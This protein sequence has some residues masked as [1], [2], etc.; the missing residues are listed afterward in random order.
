MALRT[1]DMLAGVMQ[2]STRSSRRSAGFGP[3]LFCLV[4]PWS[5][6]S[7]GAQ[8]PSPPVEKTAPAPPE[9]GQPAPSF[10]LND[11]DGK[12]VAIGGAAEDGHWTVLA[13]YPKAA[14]PG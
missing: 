7:V 9:V 10:R 1:P 11:Q 2:L 5:L 12:G 6:G 13:F 14:T 3:A 4:L 8:E